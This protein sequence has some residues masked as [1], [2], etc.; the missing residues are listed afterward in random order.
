[1]RRGGGKH[2]CV[3]GGKVCPAHLQRTRTL[4]ISHVHIDACYFLTGSA[5][6]KC[7]NHQGLSIHLLSSCSTDKC[8][9][10]PPHA[11]T[12][13]PP[14]V[15]G[16]AGGLLPRAPAGPEGHERPRPAAA[17]ATPAGPAARVCGGGAAGQSGGRGCSGG[18]GTVR[19]WEL[20]GGGGS[21]GRGGAQGAASA[22]CVLV[23]AAAPHSR[24]LHLNTVMC[25]RVALHPGTGLSHSGDNTSCG[26]DL[27]VH[28]AC[29]VCGSWRMPLQTPPGPATRC[30]ALLLPQVLWRVPRA[31]AGHRP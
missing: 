27:A 12:P 4:L 24:R 7:C 15:P 1:M 14:Q 5:K 13:P 21:G 29:R 10:H 9:D 31:A 20:A 17:P 2:P 23:S 3:Y 28:T 22:A 26:G 16:A 6:A 25:L 19:T 8:A 11:H 18:A 30:T